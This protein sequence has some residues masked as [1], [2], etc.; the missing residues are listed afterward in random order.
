[1]RNHYEEGVHIREVKLQAAKKA[2]SRILEAAQ[3]NTECRQDKKVAVIG[4]GPAGLA[5]A[6]FLSRAG[7]VR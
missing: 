3:K 2:S 6:S 4:G 7:A 1:M 5:A